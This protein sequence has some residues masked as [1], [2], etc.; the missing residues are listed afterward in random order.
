MTKAQIVP[1][2]AGKFEVSKN[3]AAGIIEGGFF[4]LPW[5]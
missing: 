1:H 3:T 4:N 5:I 2:F